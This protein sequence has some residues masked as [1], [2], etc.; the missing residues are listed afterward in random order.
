MPCGWHGLCDA[1]GMTRADLPD[2]ADCVPAGGAEW[3]VDRRYIRIVE[4]HANGMVAFE[5]AV[6]EPGLFVEMLM[7]RAQ[8]EAFCIQQ[9]VVPSHGGWSGG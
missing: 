4:E 8:F 5:F 7:P 6:G 9:G 3:D 2:N 1:W